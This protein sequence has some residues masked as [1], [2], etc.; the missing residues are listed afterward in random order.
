LVGLLAGDIKEYETMVGQTGAEKVKDAGK[1]LFELAKLP[2]KRDLRQL[3]AS[4]TNIFFPN[5]P[6]HTT[7]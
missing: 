6:E 4:L 3:G 1:D 7:F 2:G 5:G